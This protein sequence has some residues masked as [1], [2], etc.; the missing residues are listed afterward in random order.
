MLSVDTLGSNYDTVLGIWTG[1]RGS[2]SLTRDGCNDD[3]WGP[4]SASLVNVFVTSGNT[5]YFEVA[6]YNAGVSGNLTINAS[7]EG[8]LQFDNRCKPIIRRNS[9]S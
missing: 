8:L 6:S 2:L 4:G 5:Y 9:Y 1:N 7:L 3:N